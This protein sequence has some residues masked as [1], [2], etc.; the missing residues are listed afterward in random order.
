MKLM[1]DAKIRNELMNIQ[2]FT[3]LNQEE[4]DLIL[5]AELTEGASWTKIKVSQ[6][7]LCMM[8]PMT[9][10]SSWPTAS[11]M[12]IFFFPWSIVLLPYYVNFR[13]K[14]NWFSCIYGWVHI[15]IHTQYTGVCFLYF[16][17]EGYHKLLDIVPLL[18]TNLVV[19]FICDKV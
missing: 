3:Q 14:S 13:Y 1:P 8:G 2:W 11:N 5:E 10:S 16:S 17:I 15:Y 19:Y 4:F 9:G 12:E 18:Y 7:V 6:T